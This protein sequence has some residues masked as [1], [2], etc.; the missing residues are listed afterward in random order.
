M[1]GA[2]G[3]STPVPLAAGAGTG[4]LGHSTFSP[5]GALLAAAERGGWVRLWDI[6]ATAASTPNGADIRFASGA[7]VAVFSPAGTHVAV[8]GGTV[9]QHLR[10]DHA[11]RGG[12]GKPR[13]R[14]RGEERGVRA[15]RRGHR[16]A[17]RLR[18]SPGLHAG[19]L[20]PPDSSTVAALVST[21]ARRALRFIKRHGGLA[22]RYASSTCSWAP[23]CSSRAFMWPHSP[24]EAA[25]T[26]ACG[27]LS[28]VFALATIYYGGFP[29][30]ERGARGGAVRLDRRAGG[31]ARADDVAQRHRRDRAVRP[32]P[33]R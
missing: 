6:P 20:P 9:L 2:S 5:D 25:F 15:Q 21:V 19:Q 28:V 17:R 26:M 18:Q 24:L 3:F 1:L 7:D 33:V 30:P 12:A 32:G 11:C 22:C 16:R 14:L 29:L 27:G 8:A 23:G 31:V 10:P 13:P 4:T